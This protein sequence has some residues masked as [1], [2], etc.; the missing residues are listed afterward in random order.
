MNSLRPLRFARLFMA[1]ALVL[2][3]A[4][5]ASARDDLLTIGGDAFSSGTSVEVGAPSARDLFATGFSTLVTGQVDGDLH[6]AGFD[7]EIDAPVGGD[8][9]ATGF[10]VEVTGSTGSDLTASAG[11]LRVADTAAVAGNARILAGKAVLDGPV[12]GSL[13]A[14]SGSL[15]LNGAIAGDA[16]LTAGRLRFGP[17]ARVGG[18]LVYA[19]EEPIDIPSSVAPPERIR[20]DRLEAGNMMHGFGDGMMHPFEA[21]WP[22]LLSV[23]AGFVLILAFLLLLAAVFYSFAPR[24]TE[25]LR[26][27]ALA[28]PFRSML[29]GALGFA[30]LLGLVPVSAIT[31]IGIPLIP[32]VVL[33]II[34]VWIVGYLL[35]VYAIATG[36]GGTALTA[37]DTLSRRLAL[38]AVGLVVFG[39]LNFIPFLGWVLNL[40]AVFLGLGALMQRAASLVGGKPAAAPE[41][42]PY[43][44]DDLGT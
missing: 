25:D 35:G 2:A 41:P 42:S 44:S 31:L 19:S 12:G 39:L 1:T 15:E 5:V 18:M 9:Y 28:H 37:A 43:G 6:A 30:M 11:S 10:S 7:V 27:Q 22:S 29:L 17:D 26:M 21:F 33:A 14:A 32:V 34:V 8:L 24:T 38:L 4:G 23:T 16:R 13:M 40:L 20:F 3:G 36:L